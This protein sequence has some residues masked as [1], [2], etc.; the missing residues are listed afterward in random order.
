MAVAVQAGSGALRY[1]AML[2]ALYMHLGPL[3][4]SVISEIDAEFLSWTICLRI[5]ISRMQPSSPKF[6][7]WSCY[8]YLDLSLFVRL[9]GELVQRATKRR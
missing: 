2:M 9:W 1:S 5:G 3:S 8:F 6:A 7:L 4:K